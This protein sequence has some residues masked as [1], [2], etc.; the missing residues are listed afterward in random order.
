MMSRLADRRRARSFAAGVDGAP[1][2]G[3]GE[4]QA[5]VRVV[6]AVR[7]LPPVQPAA[8]FSTE[9]RAR[10]VAAA[11]R[12]HARRPPDDDTAPSAPVGRVRA[13]VAAAAGA[14]VLV[15]AGAG[16]ASA[17]ASALPGEPLYPVK[18]GFEQVDLAVAFGPYEQGITELDRAGARLDEV[19]ALLGSGTGD[20][21][22][23]VAGTLAD[24]TE[25]AAAGQELLL[26]SYASSGD[27]TGPA[28]L[29][30][31]AVDSSQTL[32]EVAPLLPAAA[33]TAFAEA[34]EQVVGTDSA[35]QQAC[36][37]CAPDADSASV[38]VLAQSAPPPTAAGGGEDASEPSDVAGAPAAEPGSV[39]PDDGS[40]GG[41]TSGGAAD[42]SA[43][44]V[45]PG[46]PDEQGAA[47]AEEPSPEQGAPPS[48]PP[49]TSS[50]TESP[51]STPTDG[52]LETQSP[53][54][55]TSAD[56]ASEPTPTGP[57]DVM[58][59]GASSDKPSPT[60]SADQRPPPS[61][62]AAEKAKA[63]DGGA[64]PAAESEPDAD[65]E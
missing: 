35:A 12:D 45:G 18:R 9:L 64:D 5:L 44:D 24:F 31:F 39:G 43:V 65:S 19:D 17:S 28:A 20:Q 13:G 51:T 37:G 47:T 40:A 3:D 21:R 22:A 57:D 61:D 11:Q 54:A 8:G 7:D 27:P 55:S 60:P 56:T 26:R 32:N 36:P 34:A 48:T 14:V 53:S 42:E 58:A 6:E 49:A 41:T 25:S 29:R 52:D 62:P 15:G 1:A 2:P 16:L 38:D 46:A 23:R 4:V 63:P 33:R 59:P 50:A 10:L 30:D